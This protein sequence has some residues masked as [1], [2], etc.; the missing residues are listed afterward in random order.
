MRRLSKKLLAKSTD[1]FVM[2][3][4]VYNKP[5][6]QYRIEGFSFFYINAW[7]LL[8]KARII[9]TTKKE[10]SIYKK[11]ERN[12][13]RISISLRDCLGVVFKEDDLVK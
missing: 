3:I 2:A 6:I 1:A 9:E 8:L 11:K 4:E 5:T 10:N 13:K 12:K 7:E